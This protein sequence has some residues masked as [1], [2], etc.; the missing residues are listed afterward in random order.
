MQILDNGEWFQ[1]KVV[2]TASDL[3]ASCKEVEFGEKEEPKKDVTE[4]L[5]LKKSR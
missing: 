2:E 5:L 3:G 1:K 4:V